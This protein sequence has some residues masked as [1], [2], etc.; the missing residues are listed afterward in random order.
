M[1]K[2]RILL[3]IRSALQLAKELA[4][5]VPN[6][7]D[8]LFGSIL[9]IISMAGTIN[10]YINPSPSPLS[11]FVSRNNLKQKYSPILKN[12]VFDSKASVLFETNQ[13]SSGGHIFLVQR[14]FNNNQSLFFELWYGNPSSYMYY[15]ENFDFAKLLDSI[16]DAHDGRVSIKPTMSGMEF[17]SFSGNTNKIFGSNKEKVFDLIARQK[18]CFEDSVNRVYL[19]HGK[20]GTGKTTSAIAMASVLGKR[21]LKLDPASLIGLGSSDMDLIIKNLHPNFIIVDD[22]DKIKIEDNKFTSLL[23]VLDEIQNN[24]SI[25]TIFTANHLSKLDE[26]VIRPG[27]IDEVHE[28]QLP[29]LADRKLIIKG[30]D[31][32]LSNSEISSLARKTNGLSPAWIKEIII[33][34]KYDGMDRA[35]NDV[36]KIHSLYNSK[37][38][39]DKKS[40]EDKNQANGPVSN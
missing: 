20:P 38:V 37:N 12:I 32:A 27:R 19:F 23:S 25:V 10:S 35:I 22:I 13:V 29:T 5:N 15:P 3:K 40:N 6:K 11:E 28:F 34:S 21:T 4:I 1:N 39:K 30:Y 2:Q 36:K 18:K 9:K 31:S 16:W 17:T 33:R 24:E 26:T 7:Q 8:K 14:I